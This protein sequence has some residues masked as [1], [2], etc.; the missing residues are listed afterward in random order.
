MIWFLFGILI[1]GLKFPFNWL[2][3]DAKFADIQ[4]V[5]RFGLY[6]G[7]G[8]EDAWRRINEGGRPLHDATNLIVEWNRKWI[9]LSTKFLCA[10]FVWT[11]ILW[12]FLALGLLF[13]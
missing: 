13:L 7:S 2:F 3:P 12:I 11:N 10:L 1:A 6:N 9:P 8:V 5:G 4:Q